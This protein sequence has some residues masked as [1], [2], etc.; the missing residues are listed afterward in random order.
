VSLAVLN[1]AYP[2]AA[3]GPDAVGGAEQVLSQLDAALVQAGHRSIVVAADGSRVHG[4]LHAVPAI[5]GA[6]GDAQRGIAWAEHRRA[7]RAAVAKHAPDVI[8]LHGI[9]CA[10][11]LPPP[12]ATPILVTLHL[13][14][15]WYPQAILSS[16]REDVHLHCVSRAQHASCP[17]GTRLLP[18]VP[19]GVPVQALA[20]RVHKRR[21]ALALGRICPEK[22]LHVALEA[23]RRAGFPV[24]LGGAVFPYPEHQQ[25]YWEHVTPLL[26]RE[27]LFLG[28]LGFA[29]K[30][31]LLAGARCLLLPTLAP[32]TSSL[33]AM[34]ALACGTPVVAFASGAIPEI[35]EH[36]VTGFLV[37]DAAEMAEAIDA[38]AQLDAERCRAVARERFP[39]E[40][41]VARYFDVYEQLARR[42]QRHTAAIAIG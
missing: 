22:N 38:C 11:Y 1:V 34:E 35:V 19:N 40:R 2:F 37:R 36:G 5:A 18:P 8:H 15:A 29:R 30:R 20:C 31:R 14:P 25:Y 12:G 27:R 6:I 42:T 3:A 24:L 21:Y 23:G 32:E 13:P 26:D 28:P 33:V 4:T 10:E 17:P 41:M 39:L 9:D 7:I 16:G